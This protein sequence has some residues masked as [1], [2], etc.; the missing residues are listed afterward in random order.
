MLWKSL[1]AGDWRRKRSE[2]GRKPQLSRARASEPLSVQ[3]LQ[4][5]TGENLPENQ[6]DAFFR[7]AF[8]PNQEELLLPGSF[9][10]S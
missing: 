5:N 8:L 4:E 1:R 6:G 10:W 3:W 7:G 9:A 2:G